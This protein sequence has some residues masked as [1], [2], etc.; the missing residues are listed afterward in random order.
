MPAKM[1]SH[2]AVP[3][4]DATLLELAQFIGELADASAKVTMPHFRSAL[5]V[6]NK[7]G[8]H[9]YDPVTIADQSAE[10]AIR[11]LIKTKHPEHGIYGEEHGFE[12]GSSGLTWV[13]DPIDG[14]RAFITGS[15][16]WGT[17]IGLH[18]GQK[19]ILGLMDQPFTGERFV[20]SRR[21]AE[22]RRAGVTLPL[23]TRPCGAI[24]QA[25]LQCTT[26]DLFKGAERDA[27]FAIADRVELRR[28]GGDCYAYALLALGQIDLVV[29]SGLFPY[30]I[31]ALIP[32]IEAAGG[33]VT[34]W[35]GGDPGNGGRI[36]AAGDRR[37]HEQALQVLS[38]V[39]DS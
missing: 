36:V 20:G 12:V 34:T 27:F 24:A 29:E 22:L 10:T 23:R 9:A 38:T 37:L 5:A 17:L 7:A 1:P 13:I 35:T 4:A 39:A 28:Y 11:T 2:P 30:D 31:Q 6:D 21:G 3:V 8:E 14:T 15:P 33:V 18:D 19:P 26:P 16:L 32:I 25:R